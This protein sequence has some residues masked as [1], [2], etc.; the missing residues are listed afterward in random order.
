[1]HMCCHWV[2]Y[3]VMGHISSVESVLSR[4]KYWQHRVEFPPMQWCT[5]PIIL[6][7][8]SPYMIVASAHG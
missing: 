4:D 3:N 8:V 7:L 6:S 2:P 1:M 5:S